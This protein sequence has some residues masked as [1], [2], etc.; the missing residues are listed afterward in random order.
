M[1]YDSWLNPMQHY[2][3]IILVSKSEALYA[4]QAG[5][6]F[7]DLF[8]WRIQDQLRICE[9][10]LLQALKD[11]KNTVQIICGTV[12]ASCTAVDRAIIHI[13]CCTVFGLQIILI[14]R[15]NPFF[16][17]KCRNSLILQRSKKYVWKIN[18]DLLIQDHRRKQAEMLRWSCS[19]E[20]WVILLAYVIYHIIF[21]SWEPST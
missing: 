17:V 10:V 3:S 8:Q 4:E 11:K 12:V 21:G 19:H 9:K 5:S 2:L 18:S 13:C 1:M 16:I 6:F 14:N 20:I 15:L 7:L